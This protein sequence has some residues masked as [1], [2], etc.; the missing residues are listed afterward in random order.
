VEPDVFA[1]LEL[2]PHAL[3]KLRAA[4]A[5]PV[6]AYLLSGPP[7]SAASD[8]ATR[9]AAALAGITLGQVQEGHPDVIEAI[10]EGQVIRLEQIA[11]IWQAVHLRPH[12]GIRVVAI[13]REAHA[14]SEIVQNALLKSIEEPP[15]HA[16]TILVT[17]LPHQ[18]LAT[19]RSRC[20]EI[21]IAP[22]PRREPAPDWVVEI[23]RG[24]LN[25]PAFDPSEA[26]ARHVKATASLER[27]ALRE[28]DERF[29]GR[30]EGAEF[31]PTAIRAREKKKT[32]AEHKELSGRRKRQTQAEAAGATVDGL[33]SWYRDVLC[34]ASGAESVV[35]HSARLPE[36]REDAAGDPAVVERAL[37]AALDTR[38]A[39]QLTITPEL[40]IE[41]LLHR[42]RLAR[43][44]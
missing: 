33:A 17:H 7:E 3:L 44:A 35:V 27:S 8:A 31:L 26:I 13:V 42:V 9:L 15:P 18:L 36:L 20:Q 21:V 12:S 28:V 39:L 6:H 25:D 43:T 1:G 22:P 11:A 29:A 2:D 40:A 24:A 5:D 4:V 32:D 19:V 10:R 30:R 23:A 41:A 14:M 37:E 38:R 16:V 34:T